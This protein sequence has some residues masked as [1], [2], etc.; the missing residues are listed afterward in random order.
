M[1]ADSRTRGARSSRRIQTRHLRLYQLR[2]ASITKLGLNVVSLIIN[3]NV[4]IIFSAS[5]CHGLLETE[6]KE[7]QEQRKWKRVRIYK[8][9][10]ETN[11]NLNG[12]FLYRRKIEQNIE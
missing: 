10:A 9:E 7:T 3:D 2:P 1:P 5:Y 11:L 12:V 6:R 8:Q 4:K